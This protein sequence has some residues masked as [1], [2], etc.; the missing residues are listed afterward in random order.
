MKRAFLRFTV[1][2]LAIFSM[3]AM[4]ATSSRATTASDV[5][6][7]AVR[8]DV[9]TDKITD[10]AITEESPGRFIATIQLTDAQKKAFA[11]LTAAHVGENV[12]VTIAGEAVLRTEIR[13]SMESISIGP[14]MNEG[15]ANLFAKCLKR[16][17]PKKCL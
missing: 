2:A 3:V 14:W 12:E 10:V 17:G 7:A 11:A 15:L 16:C 8:Y 1:S 13:G 5:P 9:T 4:A 6:S